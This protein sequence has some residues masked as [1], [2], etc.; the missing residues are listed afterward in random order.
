[1]EEIRPA[2]HPNYR[3]PERPNGDASVSAEDK[4]G[5]D[6][7]GGILAILSWL[8]EKLGSANPIQRIYVNS[9]DTVICTKFD[10]LSYDAP[11]SPWYL[12]ENH[13]KLCNPKV[14]EVFCRVMENYRGT[15][16]KNPHILCHTR[17]SVALEGETFSQHCHNALSDSVRQWIGGK[18]EIE[19]GRPQGACKEGR[20]ELSHDFLQTC[21]PLIPHATKLTICGPIREEDRLLITQEVLKMDR[22]RE[23]HFE[24][25]KESAEYFTSALPEILTNRTITDISLRNYEKAEDFKTVQEDTW[26]DLRDQDRC[27]IA[28]TNVPQPA[29]PHNKLTFNSSRM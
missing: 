9:L 27:D 8:A 10:A 28:F 16:R 14:I 22:L 20:L 29:E 12:T 25:D 2:P 13:R 19:M 21:F 1:M 3:P 7:W 5:V 6:M 11:I 18:T 17:Y 24:V 23:L 26:T 15:A 4:G